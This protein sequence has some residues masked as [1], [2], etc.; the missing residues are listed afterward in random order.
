MTGKKT[1]R[2]HMQELIAELTDRDPSEDPIVLARRINHSRMQRLEEL[3]EEITSLEG[4]EQS[5]KYPGEVIER[6]AKIV[7]AEHQSIVQDIEIEM[8]ALKKAMTDE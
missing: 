8:E 5:G 3:S 4:M 2:K 1:I 6:A 7:A